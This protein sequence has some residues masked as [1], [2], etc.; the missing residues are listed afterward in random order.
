MMN[1]QM[2]VVFL[3]LMLI[4]GM[5]VWGMNAHPWQEPTTNGTVSKYFCALYESY[6]WRPTNN[7][8]YCITH[9]LNGPDAGQYSGL[10]VMVD[11]GTV[12]H[13]SNGQA[14][15][16]T[17]MKSRYNEELAKKEEAKLDK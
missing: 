9:V 14:S 7:K 4:A 8:F 2:R 5:N 10:I 12:G 3:S 17:I 1:K 11:S 15:L 13:L 16:F 6:V